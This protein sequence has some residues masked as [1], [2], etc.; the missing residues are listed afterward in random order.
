MAATAYQAAPPGRGSA[1]RFGMAWVTW[2]QHRAALTGACGVLGV[3]IGYM[4]VTGLR[5][6]SALGAVWLARRAA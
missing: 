4:L 5:M 2:R 1:P 6:R 3:M